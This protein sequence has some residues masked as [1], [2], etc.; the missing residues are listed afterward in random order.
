MTTSLSDPA[1]GTIAR[2]PGD[3]PM[4]SGRGPT[5]ATAVGALLVAV[6]LAGGMGPITDNSFLTH[7]AT[8][9]LILDTGAVPS[10]DPYTFT[11][12]GEPWVVQSWLASILYAGLERA[13]GLWAVSVLHGVLAALVVAGVW[14]LTRTVADLGTRV[15][16]VASVLLTGSVVWA[17]RPLMFGLLALVA[18]LLALEGRLRTP[19]LLPVFWIWGATH[20]SFPIG[21]AVIAAFVAGRW[22]DDRRLPEHE[23]R[24]L[25]WAGLGAVSTVLGPLGVDALVFPATSLTQQEALSFMK[26]WQPPA[27]RS[28]GE[29]GFLALVLTAGAVFGRRTAPWRSLLPTGLAVVMAL[30]AIRNL[31]VATVVIVAALVPVLAGRSG[32]TPRIDPATRGIGA[33]GGLLAAAVVA[34]V[35]LAGAIVSDP[36]ELSAYPV[37]EV[38]YLELRGLLGDP[39]VRVIAREAVGNYLGFR[40]GPQVPVFAD[41]RVDML[42][43]VVVGDLV[44]FQRGGDHGAALDRWDADVVL[45]QRDEALSYW[46]DASPD[47]DRVHEGEDWSVYCRAVSPA[48]SRCQP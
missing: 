3:G 48:R 6:G 5:I 37:D 39:E 34:I 29:L 8:G 31:A 41:D 26:E 38:T 24:V 12:P 15:L 44:T 46:L 47:W 9:R 22:L 28:A 33:T 20:G 11:A 40:Y 1:T 45:W 36:L 23:L 25:L 27:W 14:A 35:A 16:L 18:C 42:P 21:L 2:E 13:A 32:I 19:W 30:L 43:P 17:P 7:L 10:A 4:R